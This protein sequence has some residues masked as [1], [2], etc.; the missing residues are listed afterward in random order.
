M[1]RLN[2]SRAHQRRLLHHQNFK[3]PFAARLRQK[4]LCRLRRLA[5]RSGQ[6]VPPAIFPAAGKSES[7][8][9]RRRRFSRH[10]FGRVALREIE[11]KN[12]NPNRR[13]AR[14]NP[15]ARPDQFQ[16]EFDLN[17]EGTRQPAVRPALLLALLCCSTLPPR[18]AGESHRVW[19]RR[20]DAGQIK[21]HAAFS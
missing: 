20:F 4:W 11:N 16:P 7:F 13:Q 17:N 21:C 8:P 2:L 10:Q 12:Q 15:A 9:A 14:P 3:P 1:T 18:L 5:V 19:A 6:S